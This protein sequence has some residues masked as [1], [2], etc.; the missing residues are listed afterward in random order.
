MK[1]L[2]LILF[3]AFSVYAIAPTAYTDAVAVWDFNQGDTVA[4][5]DTLSSA[6]D[7]VN[8]WTDFNPERGWEYILTTTGLWTGTGSDSITAALHF[9][10]K[11]PNGTTMC[12]TKVDTYTTIS[13]QFIALPF[14][15]SP[16]D[17]YDILLDAY[18]AIGSQVIVPP[19]FIMFRRKPVVYPGK[20]RQ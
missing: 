19:K 13:G 7:T 5:T 10:S 15:Q 17:R 16:A 11:D 9:R 14:D 20:W 4:V 1:K 3:F 8:L 6:T 18:G 2:F 12:T